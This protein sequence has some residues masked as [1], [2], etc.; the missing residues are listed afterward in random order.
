MTRT[1]VS[2]NNAVLDSDEMDAL[3]KVAGDT[4]SV[5]SPWAQPEYSDVRDYDF[6]SP[7]RIVH[8]F[9]PQL[10]LVNERFARTFRPALFNMLRQY[11]DLGTGTIAVHSFAEYMQTLR[12]PVS[13]NLVRIKPLRGTALIVYEPRLVYSIVDSFF[14]GSGRPL[15]G[16]DRD[17]TPSELRIVQMLL[18]HTFDALK[19]GWSYILP[20]DFEFMYSESN[21][22]FASVMVSSESDVMVVTRFRIRL[23]EE[24][25]E[26]HVALPYSMLEPLRARLTAPI[27][28]SDQDPDR[29]FLQGLE[30]GMQDVDVELSSSM[31]SVTISLQDLMGLSQGDII[32]VDIPDNITLNVS[33][34]PMFEGSYGVLHG[35]AAVQIR[36]RLRNTSAIPKN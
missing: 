28:N 30:D 32:P 27:Q 14:G 34:I 3:L 16:E 18:E 2:D 21:P 10:E 20:L 11:A 4:S 5:K 15:P 1:D 13:I 19:H 31:T 24:E 8:S 33:E 29:K 26:F 36:K 7:D 9:L 6:A 25:G 35:G 23:G 12:A 17:F 22:Q